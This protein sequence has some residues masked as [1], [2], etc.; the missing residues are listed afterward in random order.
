MNAL[1][2][3]GLT[4]DMVCAKFAHTTFDRQIQDT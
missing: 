2:T 1:T 4:Q 3:T